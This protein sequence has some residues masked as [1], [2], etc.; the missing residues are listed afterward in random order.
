MATTDEPAGA[1]NARYGPGEGN[2]VPVVEFN[3]VNVTRPIEVI[4]H[5]AE[6]FYELLDAGTSLALLIYETDSDQTAITHAMVREDRRG[7]GLGSTLIASALNDLAAAGAKVKN[8]CTS[9]ADFLG[10][11]PE[12]ER[13]VD[14]DSRTRQRGS[15]NDPTV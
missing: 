7:N 1:T 8:Y 10:K 15:Q 14:S 9:V 12:Y 2:P 3:L 6:R 13:L 4:H 5:P 11:H